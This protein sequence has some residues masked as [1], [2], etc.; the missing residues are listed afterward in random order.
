MILV[1]ALMLSASTACLA[2]ESTMP[3]IYNGPVAIA[4]LVTAPQ[5]MGKV[6]PNKLAKA[7]QDAQIAR[8]AA[9]QSHPKTK[10]K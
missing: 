7:K 4:P 10:R 1:S 9:L 3:D 6:P 2:Q 8:E 5:L